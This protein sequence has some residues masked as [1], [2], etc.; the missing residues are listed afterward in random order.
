MPALPIPAARLL[1]RIYEGADSQDG[2]WDVF[3]WAGDQFLFAESKRNKKDSIRN[4]Q[5]KWLEAALGVGL[6]PDNFLIVQ[7]SLTTL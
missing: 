3:C 2:A 1:A 6:E 7:W 4:P 5:K